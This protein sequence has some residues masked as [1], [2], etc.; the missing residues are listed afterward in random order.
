MRQSRH[1]NTE[2]FPAGFRASGQI[3][4]QRLF[5]DAGRLT[6][7][8]RVRSDLQRLRENC[9]RNAW[10][11]TV[12]DCFRGFRRDVSLRESGSSGRENDIDLTLIR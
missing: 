6:A 2:V 1:Q 4:D 9:H 10:G 3:D 7:Q 11:H 12:A 8:H 5:P